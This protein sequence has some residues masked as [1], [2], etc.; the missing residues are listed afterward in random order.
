MPV[1]WTK[2]RLNVRIVYHTATVT[3]GGGRDGRVRSTG[4]FIDLRAA[5]PEEVGGPGG[6]TNPLELFAAESDARLR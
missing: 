2:G 4:S 3:A 5:L 6:K 1:I